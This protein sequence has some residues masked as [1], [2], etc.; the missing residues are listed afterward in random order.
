MTVRQVA[1]DAGALQVAMMGN[2]NPKQHLTSL[3]KRLGHLHNTL[4]KSA[5]QTALGLEPPALAAEKALE[6]VGL[7]RRTA[8]GYCPLFLVVAAEEV[9]PVAVQARQPPRRKPPAWSPAGP[10]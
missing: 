7:V 6:R 4:S 9:A 3:R 2:G 10:T 5:L 8:D 1:P